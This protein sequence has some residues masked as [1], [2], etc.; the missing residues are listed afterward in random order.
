MSTTNEAIKDSKSMS[1]PITN[2]NMLL[3]K[4]AQINEEN[5]VTS[6]VFLKEIFLLTEEENLLAK[7]QK[8]FCE[9]NKIKTS[10]IL[11]KRKR[12]VRLSPSEGMLNDSMSSQFNLNL[13][14]SQTDDTEDYVY[15]HLSKKHQQLKKYKILQQEKTNNANLTDQGACK[16]SDLIQNE[17]KVVQIPELAPSAAASR[18]NG[19]D[20]LGKKWKSLPEAAKNLMREWYEIHVLNPYPTEAERV[21][22]SI[23]GNISENQVKAWFANKR[24]RA[25]KKL[26]V[27]K[28]KNLK[29][30]SSAVDLAANLDCE[31]KTTLVETVEMTEKKVDSVEKA[32]QEAAN[33][34]DESLKI[35]N[36]V[37]RDNLIV[38]SNVPTS[39]FKTY[40]T[41][42]K[43]LPSLCKNKQQVASNF[44][45][46]II[47]L[48][49]TTKSEVS[50]LKR[51]R[52]IKQ[53][54]IQPKPATSPNKTPTK[55]LVKINPLNASS[56]TK[57]AS[58]NK[59]NSFNTQLPAK[60]RLQQCYM[61]KPKGLNNTFCNKPIRGAYESKRPNQ[62]PENCGLS[63]SKF[64]VEGDK[65]LPQPDLLNHSQ[66]YQP[67]FH[68]HHHHQQQQQQQ[69]K[70][71]IKY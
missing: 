37:E 68:H 1:N 20:C 4:L 39:C 69:Y 67:H 9:A 56:I 3:N 57:V 52:P 47:I 33:A 48:D 54:L 22:M 25:S 58:V 41:H 31:L 60:N 18:F 66:Q 65:N 30:D 19:S 23:K 17:N 64:K 61:I 7:S 53:P 14:N 36:V 70:L 15:E 8:N 12:A 45:E 11:N 24:N 6:N 27:T 63:V 40:P 62:H 16:H 42:K 49:E 32:N 26:D 34:N 55:I 35:L 29:P 50:N 5:K 2:E 71:D 43:L 46:P 10:T 21:D 13:D 44:N 38:K 28:R 51:K 59:I